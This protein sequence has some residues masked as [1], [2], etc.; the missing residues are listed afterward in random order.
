MIPPQTAQINC[1]TLALRLIAWQST[2]TKP[3]KQGF[4]KI[5]IVE[6]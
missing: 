4:L 2:F 3:Q 1:A 6:K 5:A